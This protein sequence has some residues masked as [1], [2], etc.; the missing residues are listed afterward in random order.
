MNISQ[1]F[2]IFAATLP[3]SVSRQDVVDGDHPYQN[4]A[5][6]NTCGGCCEIKIK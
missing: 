3:F 1:A 4:P 2:M 5:A 6:D